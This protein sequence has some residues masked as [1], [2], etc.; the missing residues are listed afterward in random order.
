MPRITTFLAYESR[1]QEAVE[2][3]VSIFKNSRIVH[4]S[5]YGE[6][7]PGAKGSVMTIDFELN[8]QPFTALNGGAHFKFTDGISLSVD[9]ESQAEVDEYLGEALRRRRRGTLRLAEGPLRRVVASQPD[10]PRRDASGSRSAARQPR[11]AGDAEDEEDRYPGAEEGVRG[12][13]VGRTRPKAKGQAL[14]L[15]PAWSSSCLSKR[16]TRSRA[17]ASRTRRSRR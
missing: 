7:G 14:G 17:P 4:T 10:D 8:D 2:Q 16:S 13:N 5:Y 3:Y 15:I 12:G 9:C 6:A 11:D 1:A